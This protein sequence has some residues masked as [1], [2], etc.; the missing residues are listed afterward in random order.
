ME[1][2]KLLQLICWAQVLYLAKNFLFFLYWFRK[3]DEFYFVK[4]VMMIFVL[5]C[6]TIKKTSDTTQISQL[7]TIEPELSILWQ[8]LR[9]WSVRISPVN[10]TTLL[11]LTE[12]FALRDS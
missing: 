6:T 4:L 1:L 7:T 9:A 2:F 11:G 3:G 8:A 10:V 12:C 5:Y